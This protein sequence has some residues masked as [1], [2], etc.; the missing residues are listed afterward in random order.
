MQPYHLLSSHQEASS[1]YTQQSNYSRSV[2]YRWTGEKIAAERHH[3]GHGV[4]FDP[5]QKTGL[6]R[7]RSCLP[8]IFL[9][10]LH[11]RSERRVEKGGREDTEG[12]KNNQVARENCRERVSV[13]QRQHTAL[14]V[15]S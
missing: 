8:I 7:D 2:I 6:S 3:T 15:D 10:C 1:W 4:H 13:G 14:P 12:L 5:V 9:R 11:S